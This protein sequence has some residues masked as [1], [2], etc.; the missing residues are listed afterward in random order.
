M[1]IIRATHLD[2]AEVVVLALR[3]WPH[4]TQA[5]LTDE[6]K[7]LLE[8]GKTVVFLAS[9]ERWQVAFAQCS[10]RT[11]YVEGTEG[12]PVG[13]LEGIYVSPECRRRGVA[14]ALIRACEAWA[15]ERGCRQ[16][17]SDCELDNDVSLVFHVGSGF[18][19]ANRVI[20]FVKD[21]R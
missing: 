3:L 17:A 6:F 10:I 5:E 16:L 8:A 13:Y 20:C 14:K 19:E 21:I 12:S 1:Q 4:H 15:Q 2:I 7:E 18:K 9:S 11:D